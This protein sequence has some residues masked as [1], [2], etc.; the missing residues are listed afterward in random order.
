[1]EKSAKRSQF[2]L[3][4]AVFRLNRSDNFYEL[5]PIVYEDKGELVQKPLWLVVKSLPSKVYSIRE[6]DVIKLGKQKL[7]VREV[8]PLDSNSSVVIANKDNISLTRAVY[9]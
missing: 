3:K 6:K 5:L 1:M 2:I 9:D 4:D 7:K 8:V